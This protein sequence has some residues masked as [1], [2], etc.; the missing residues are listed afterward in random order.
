MIGDAGAGWVMGRTR[1][2]PREG[3]GGGTTIVMQR[4]ESSRRG[5]E[6]HKEEM[7]RAVGSLL[8]VL[9]PQ[10]MQDVFTY[11]ITAPRVPSR[12]LQQASHAEAPSSHPGLS[13]QVSP[14]S[15]R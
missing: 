10:R 7:V 15:E 5:R 13:L 2:G 14:S 4:P 6:V 12:N 8:A 1:R 9:C 11:I 3:R